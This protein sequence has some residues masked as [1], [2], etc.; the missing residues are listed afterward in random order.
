MGLPAKRLRI[1]KVSGRARAQGWGTVREVEGSLGSSPQEGVIRRIPSACDLVLRS[2]RGSLQVLAPSDQGLRPL[3]RCDPLYVRS[4]PVLQ[5]VGFLSMFFSFLPWL[6]R[7]LSCSVLLLMRCLHLFVL[8]M[9]VTCEDFRLK[10][11]PDII[12]DVLKDFTSD[13]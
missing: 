1:P 10:S 5:F 2:A 8:R 6:H 9:F 13:S 11:A 7:A 12:F 3:R 4:E